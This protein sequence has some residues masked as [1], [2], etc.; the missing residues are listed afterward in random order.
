MM[1]NAIGLIR[2]VCTLLLC[3]ITC[4]P[5]CRPDCYVNKPVTYN[6]YMYMYMYM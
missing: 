6:M 3:C 5:L 1:S 2:L 4:H